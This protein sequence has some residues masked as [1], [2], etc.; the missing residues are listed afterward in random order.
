MNKYG[1]LLMRQWK[2]A[3]PE[4]FATIADPER[5]F[6]AK[7]EE[8]AGEIETLSVALAG[9]DQPGETFVEKTTRL[10]SARF[11]AESDLVREAMIPEPEEVETPLPAEWRS[12]AW[13]D[14][15]E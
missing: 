2:R 9:Q 15:T 3:D 14:P 5:F 13:E 7:G 6:T 12:L 4:R 10:S 1:A 11:N 8:L